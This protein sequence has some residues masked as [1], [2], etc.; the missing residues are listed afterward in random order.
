MSEGIKE[1]AKEL[2]HVTITPETDLMK[3]VEEVH[4]EKVP[5]LI[6]RDGEALAVIVS[7]EE[8]SSLAGVP[9]S[10][11]NKEKIL[12]LAGAWKDLDADAMIEYIYKARH[13]AP[14]SP[15]VSL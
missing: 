10:K 2:K 8:Y 3:L 4:V 15:P 5:L 13:E 14:P 9:K 12:A 11:V 6:E 7:A 1:M